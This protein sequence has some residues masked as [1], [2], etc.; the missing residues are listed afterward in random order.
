MRHGR[1]YAVRGCWHRQVPCPPLSSSVRYGKVQ[2]PDLPIGKVTVT[3]NEAVPTQHVVHD[4]SSEK[5]IRSTVPHSRQCCHNSVNA[6]KAQLNSRPKTPEIKSARVRAEWGRGGKE[7][8]G[9][10]SLSLLGYRNGISVA[11]VAGET[12]RRRAK[13]PFL[14]IVDQKTSRTR[15]VRGARK[16]PSKKK[17]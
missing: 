8:V 6:R 15:T 12:Q 10:S 9:A 13:R 17:A 5:S 4:T 2:V 11:Q 14:P 1:S 7:G 16:P 3:V